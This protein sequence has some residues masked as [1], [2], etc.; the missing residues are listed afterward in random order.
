MSLKALSSID[1]T[2]VLKIKRKK[3][4]CKYK[5]ALFA[6][7]LFRLLR[8]TDTTTR[9][10]D[11]IK[12]RVHE[13]G[14]EDGEDFFVI[15]R[16]STG[17]RR[18]TDYVISL[19]MAKELAMLEK[20]PIGRQV[21]KYFIACEEELKKQK[22]M[23]MDIVAVGKQFRA[24]K[25]IAMDLGFK[26]SDAINKA[27]ELVLLE[28]NIDVYRIF[29]DSERIV[30]EKYHVHTAAQI[31]KKLSTSQRRFKKWQVE[32]AFL[33]ALV[34]RN[35]SS[36]NKNKRLAPSGISDRS[37]P[38]VYSYNSDTGFLK[39]TDLAVDLAYVVLTGT[40]ADWDMENHKPR[41]IGK[42]RL[43]NTFK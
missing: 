11:F 14:F 41:E 5:E 22:E 1:I 17:G 24:A 30:Y 12:Q 7:D 34:I 42:K 10:V 31:A 32:D 2:N 8:G 40:P 3:I 4:G 23:S 43:L 19:G 39:Y 28:S 25:S 18:A 27:R 29:T 9:F 20:T 36:S 16:K 37:K 35:L 26:E 21:R 13:Y 15:Q 6:K 38:Y 33:R